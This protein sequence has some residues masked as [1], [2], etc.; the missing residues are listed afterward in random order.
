MK[1]ILVEGHRG[2]CA[3]YPEN[4]LISFEAAI[5][6]GVDAIEFDVWLSADKVPVLMHD[7][8]AFRTCRVA[9]TLVTM[10]LAEIKAELEPAYTEK[11]GD[12]FV[13]KGITVPT[14]EELLQLCAKK[15]LAM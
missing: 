6:L 14:L 4:T 7:R 2:Y 13:N 15:R 9:R 12:E 11:F 10:T 5:D 3:K 8:N 1:K